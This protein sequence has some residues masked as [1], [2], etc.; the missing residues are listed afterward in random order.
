MYVSTIFR[1]FNTYHTIGTG[2]GGGVEPVII[3]SNFLHNKMTKIWTSDR[4]KAFNNHIN[5]LPYSSSGDGRWTA[6]GISIASNFYKKY[7]VNVFS[8][9]DFDLYSGSGNSTLSIPSN[10]YLGTSDSLQIS[11]NLFDF[12]DNNTANAIVIKNFRTTPCDSCPGVVWKLTINDKEFASNS[13]KSEDIIELGVHKIKVWFNRV[14]DTTV[15]P[16]ISFGQREP[17]NQVSFTNKGIWSTD[18]KSYEVSREFVLTDPNGIVNFNVSGAKDNMGMEIPY[19][20]R[21]FRINL[22]ST[23]SKSLNFN[24]NPQCGK[25]LLTWDNLRTTGSDIIG[26]NLYRRKK[27]SNNSGAF[28]LLN[29]TLVTQNIYTDYKVDIDSA[30]DYV[31]TAVRAGMNNETDSSFIVTGQPL[32]SKLAD[33]NGDSAINVSDVVTAVNR[34]LQKDPQPFILKQTDMNNDGIINVLDVIGIINRILNPSTGSVDNRY[35]YNSTLSAGKL[36]L[37][38]I[39]DTLYGKSDMNVAGIEYGGSLIKEWLAE[40]KNWEVVSKNENSADNKMAFTYDQY[41]E[42]NKNIPFAV[43]NKNSF[44]P[45][46]WLISTDD[47]RPLDINW[48]GNVKESFNKVSSHVTISEPFPNPTNNQLTVN[49]YADLNINNILFEILD[50]SGRKLNVIN[51]GS[52]TEGVTTKTI[53]LKELSTG[54]YLVV[55]RWKEGESEFQKIL[56]VIKN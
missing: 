47:G 23:A 36:N 34:I 50:Y 6:G 37:Y 46:D 21:R 10:I 52:I 44:N 29:N 56:N 11:K 4:F 51:K 55:I 14:M 49:I 35:D 8:N 54:P 7:P 1:N 24:L 15:N 5:N 20:R 2:A 45:R 17:F 42:K 32:R 16:S 39:G 33:A 12:F 43:V 28:T 53:S 22:Q 40:T 18:K 3:S 31:Y 25:L 41:L 26:Y 38:L 9:L 19:E 48:L 13:A 27:T 30:Y